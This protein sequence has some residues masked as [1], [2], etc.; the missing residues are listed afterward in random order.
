M[1]GRDAAAGGLRHR[2]ANVVI[3]RERTCVVVN[4]GFNAPFS[5]LPALP[6]ADGPSRISIGFFSSQRRPRE[7]RRASFGSWVVA[8][9]DHLRPPPLFL[10]GFKLCPGNHTLATTQR[11]S[12]AHHQT[13]LLKNNK[14]SQWSNA[15]TPPASNP[16]S[17]PPCC[18]SRGSKTHTSPSL[19]SRHP[20]RSTAMGPMAQSSRAGRTM[21]KVKARG[22]LRASD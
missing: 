1:S 5:D 21:R 6:R 13:I 22:K 11:T 4:T 17:S 15:P 19:K 12:I 18:P 20:P 9:D 16:R 10:A 8:L 7:R 2:L 14:P 3:G